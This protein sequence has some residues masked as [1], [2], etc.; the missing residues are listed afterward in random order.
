MTMTMTMSMTY[1]TIITTITALSSGSNHAVVA[2]SRTNEQCIEFEK[3]MP[4]LP[5]R[6]AY[7]STR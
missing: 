2:Q 4:A 3:G 7:M 1:T 6:Q 5:L